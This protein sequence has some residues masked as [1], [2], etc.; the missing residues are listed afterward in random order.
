MYLADF[1]YLAPTDLDEVIRQLRDDDRECKVIAGGQSLIPL[2]KLKLA[3]PN[4]LVDLRR[5][6]E[7]RRP[8]RVEDG[9]LVLSSM[10]CYSQLLN[11]PLVAEHAPLLCAAVRTVADRQVRRL[12]TIGGTCAHADPAGDAPAALVALNATFIIQGPEG[13]RALDAPEFFLGFM[14][15]SLGPAEVLVEIRIPST[16]G[17]KVSYQKAQGNAQ[18]WA[19]AAV[20][21]AVQLEAGEIKRACVGM[22]NLGMTPLRAAAAQ[23]LLIGRT[24]EADVIR[25]AARAA[26]ASSSPPSDVFASANYRMHLAEV[27]TVRAIEDALG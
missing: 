17:W 1:A 21:V 10:T 20:G 23:D 8:V 3:A 27:L 16:A 14:E 12:G 26:A 24:Y 13:R 7:L 9:D 4:L 22:C 6:P 2:L 25:A 19:T 15:T 11:D 18:A 5:V